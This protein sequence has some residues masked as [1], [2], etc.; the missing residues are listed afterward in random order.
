MAMDVFAGVAVS[1]FDRAVAWF[2]RLLGKA[3]TFRAN[4]TDLV[5][6]LSEHGHIYV[7]LRPD[8]AGCA[9]VTVF[10]D[11]LDDV[12]KSAA[13]RGIHPHTVETLDN[14]VRK[15]IYLDPEGNEIAFGGAPV[16]AG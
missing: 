3:P 2:E 6:T 15:A 9:M 4:D 5:W 7:K 13:E 16:Q 10:V 14:G 11:D 8:R 1:D 12:V